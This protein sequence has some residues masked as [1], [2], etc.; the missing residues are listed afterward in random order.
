MAPDWSD[1]EAVIEYLETN[2]RIAQD[3]AA[4]QKETMVKRGYLSRAA[5]ACYWRRLIRSWGETVRWDES[6]WGEGM[7]WETFSLLG[8]TTYDI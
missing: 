3:I 1:L 4:R 2:P 6:E 8:K 5:E 7:R